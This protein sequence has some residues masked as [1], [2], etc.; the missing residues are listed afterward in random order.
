MP[1]GD[2]AAWKAISPS[3]R[4][5]LFANRVSRV[6]HVTGKAPP[7]TCGKFSAPGSLGE[8]LEDH[9]QPCGGHGLPVEVEQHRLRC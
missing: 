8:G 1:G 9:A 6:T 4:S 7:Y 2:P 3:I 5:A